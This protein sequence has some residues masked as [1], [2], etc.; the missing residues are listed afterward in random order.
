[1]TIVPLKNILTTNI[2]GALVF[3]SVVRTLNAGLAD[4]KLD[5]LVFMSG[6]LR[7]FKAQESLC[8]TRKI[9]RCRR[10]LSQRSGEHRPRVRHITRNHEL[11]G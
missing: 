4:L 9:S 10:S 8:Y 2:V 5:R 11:C 3:D 1:M 6:E 7:P